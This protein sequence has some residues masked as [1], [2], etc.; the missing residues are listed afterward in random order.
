MCAASGLVALRAL[1]GCG[2]SSTGTEANCSP[3]AIGVGDK[4][5]L[6]IGQARYVESQA[7]FI[8][9]DEGGFYAIDAACTHIGTDIDFV[10][11]TSG[12][13]C[14]LHGAT[15]DFNGHVLTGPAMRDLPHYSVCST[16]SGILIVDLGARVTPDTRLLA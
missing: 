6:P 1:P 4:A 10:N 3:S 8:C 5:S 11:A 15:Y 13:K 2:S 14:P 9:H 12:F 7:I 16:E